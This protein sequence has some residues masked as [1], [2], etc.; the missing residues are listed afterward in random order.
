M[1]TLIMKQV[2]TD[3]QKYYNDSVNK[4]KDFFY[5][6]N[7]TTAAWEEVQ[8]KLNE[9]ENEAIYRGFVSEWYLVAADAF[10]LYFFHCTNRKIEPCLNDF[11][12]CIASAATIFF[13]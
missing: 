1:N 6:I 11:V 12:Q 10:E 13:V 3:P 4:Y 9:Y 7:V 5:S 2:P 8:K